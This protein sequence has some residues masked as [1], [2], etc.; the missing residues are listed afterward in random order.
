MK[1]TIIS[2]IKEIPPPPFSPV[3][4]MGS[5]R[6]KTA[7][8]VSL[9]TTVTTKT[10]VS[11]LVL[12]VFI[13]LTCHPFLPTSKASMDVL[14]Q[15]YLSPP[16]RF[17]VIRL[18]RLVEISPGVPELC[19][20]IMWHPLC[21][22]CGWELSLHLNC[23]DSITIHLS[24]PGSYGFDTNCGRFRLCFTCHPFL[25]PMGARVIYFPT[26]FFLNYRSYVYL[27]WLKLL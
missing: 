17:E 8:K 23:V 27:V 14:P 15:Q 12:V 13:V 25:P 6:L 11:S 26:I 20:N 16:P 7:F 3:M 24:N 2:I 5:E 19:W 1:S 22:Q 9:F 4:S 10:M 18:P 21:P